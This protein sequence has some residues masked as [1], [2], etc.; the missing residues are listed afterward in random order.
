MPSVMKSEFSCPTCKR[1]TGA[2]NQILANAGELVCSKDPSHKW[3]DTMEFLNL[4]PSM[5]FKVTM[6]IAPQENRTPLNIPVPVNL[7]K[8][9]EKKYGDKLFATVVAIL[10][11]MNEGTAMLIPNTD[12][13]RLVERLGA[14][15]N[16]S[17][18]LVGLVYSKTCEAED[19]KAERDTV[20]KD[21]KAYE[22]RYPGRVIVD[23]G[24]QANAA[25][26]KAVDA[27]MPVKLWVETNLK[28]AIES[29]WF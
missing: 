25:Q 24:P 23:L 29:N 18:E 3:N 15:F 14:K 12:V 13:E 6:A 9:L 10:N 16:N 21:L 22:D 5:D 27:N 7:K 17:S 26:A 8:E 11:Q 4:S 20:L 19:A 2:L 28:T 1:S